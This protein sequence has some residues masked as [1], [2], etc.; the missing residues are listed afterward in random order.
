MNRF[1]TDLL[2]IPG[3]TPV[4]PPIAR[5]LSEPAISHRGAEFADAFHASTAGLKTAFGTEGDVIILACSGTGGMEAAIANALSPGDSVVTVEIGVFGKRW[6]NITR[7]FGCEVTPVEFEWGKAADPAA[8]DEAL[9]SAPKPV[10]AVALTHN[11]TSTG[12]LNP[13]RELLE[14][15]RS[16]GA[17]TIVDCISGLLA[18]EFLMDEWGAD[19]AV[20]GSQKAFAIPPGL[21]FVAV[22]PRG[23]E[24]IESATSPT[25]YFDLP[26]MRKTAEKGQTSYTASTTL[27]RALRVALD[28]LLVDGLQ[29][30]IDRH[31]AMG[32]GVRV[33]VAAMGLKLFSDEAHASNA[34]TAILPPDGLDPDKIRSDLAKRFS[35]VFSGGQADLKGRIFRIAHLGPIEPY[36]MLGALACLEI[37]LR[38]QGYTAFPPGAGVAAAAGVLGRATH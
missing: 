2:L 25:F 36:Q 22:S 30:I 27:V 12:V 17:L 24:E 6:S 10:K 26:A 23:W 8:L 35:I 11:E 9:R 19:I 18:T 3:P 4:P 32:A 28:L 20:G 16:H 5:V 37:V 29:A 13:T 15:A 31:T 1:E 33:A 7:R 38:E 14:V 34:V 21:A